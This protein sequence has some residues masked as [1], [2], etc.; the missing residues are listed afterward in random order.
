MWKF[1]L[2]FQNKKAFT[3]LELVLGMAIISILITTL[4]TCL[5]FT[6]RVN[7]KSLEED[8]I[9]LNGRYI[10]EYIKEEIRSAD[11]I[12]DSSRFYKL[13]SKFPRNI[14]F[15]ILEITIGPVVKNSPKKDYDIY[16]YT[17][18]YFQDDSIIRI[19][20]KVDVDK[21][22]DL[23]I[24]EI[25]EKLPGAD[26]FKGYNNMGYHILETSKISLKENNIISFDLFFKNE[27]SEISN[28]K[29]DIFVRCK[30][31]EWYEEEKLKFYS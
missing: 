31:V 20:T 9:L 13:D 27:K 29:S 25:L 24:E 19:N 21:N 14:G 12:I 28:F 15:V 22:G 2:A 8:E 3:L 30:V 11:R 17:T 16:S 1:K 4:Y 7:Q 5:T 18:Y 6:L 10:L 26:H 23:S